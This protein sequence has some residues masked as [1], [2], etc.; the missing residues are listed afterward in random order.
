MSKR[1]K[2][3]GNTGWMGARYGIRIRRRVLDI[4]RARGKDAAC[5]K[6]STV[7][8]GPGRL[9]RLRVPPVRR[10]VRVRR[11]P[12]HRA[13]PDHPLREA[14]REREGDHGP[15]GAGPGVV[16]MFRCIRCGE[17]LPTDS[18]LFGVRCD[19]CGGKIF[20]KEHPNVKK[21]LKAR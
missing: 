1:T 14:G 6:C 9:G 7:T 17:P 3:V 21:V 2:K 12:V 15:D 8:V 18:N 20:T 19:N 11:V 4:D 16:P 10:P 13:A 5:P